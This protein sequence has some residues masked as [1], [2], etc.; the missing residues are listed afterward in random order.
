MRTCL[1]RLVQTACIVGMRCFHSDIFCVDCV[2]AIWQTRSSLKQ[3][4]SE[5]SHN[6]ESACHEDISRQIGSAVFGCHRWFP[7]CKLFFIWHTCLV[8]PCSATTNLSLMF[9][10]I[11]SLQ[12]PACTSQHTMA[13]PSKVVAIL[14]LGVLMA[15]VTM[16]HPATASSFKV[17]SG[18][19]CGG[20]SATLSA[21]G[22]SNIPSGDNGGYSWTY[23]GQTGA[24]YNSQGCTGA[25]HTQFGSPSISGCSAFGW[26]SFWIQCWSRI[27][28]TWIKMLQA[29]LEACMSSWWLSPWIS[30]D[31]HNSVDISAINSLKWNNLD[32][33]GRQWSLSVMAMS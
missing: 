6:R 8:T 19:G 22:C 11:S 9:S 29:E 4:Q 2:Q 21:C 14:C 15:L 17:Y 18:P 12:T 24:A 7:Q 10:L 28:S 33:N 31:N 5:Y 23:T 27:T 1:H 20:S 32:A 26:Q 30:S 3:V 16:A 13:A 25:S